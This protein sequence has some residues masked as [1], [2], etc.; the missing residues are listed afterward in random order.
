MAPRKLKYKKKRFIQK[1][2]KIQ[3]NFRVNKFLINQSLTNN[4]IWIN[5][6]QINNNICTLVDNSCQVQAK[7]WTDLQEWCQAKL[8][9]QIFHFME[10]DFQI[11]INKFLNTNLMIKLST[12]ANMSKNTPHH[13]VFTSET[14]KKE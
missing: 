12:T 11:D 8:A 5:K 10:I 4:I 1:W 14:S 13:A 3:C 7:W 9:V 2:C 6:S